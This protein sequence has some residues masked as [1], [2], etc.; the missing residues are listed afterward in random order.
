MI[1]WFLDKNS[2]IPLYLQLKD[3]IKYYISTGAIS[4]SEQLPGVINLSKELGI[5]FETVGKAYKELEKEGLIFTKRGKG[6]FVDLRK[7]PV[8]SPGN[9][10][11][12][13]I[14][15][16]PATELKHA[17]KRLLLDGKD[18]KDVESLVSGILKEV[19]EENPNAFIIFTECSDFQVQEI[20]QILKT[21]LNLDVKPVLVEDLKAEMDRI[22]ETEHNLLSIVTTGFHLNEVRKV[23]GHRP[24][25]IQILITYMGPETRSRL[26]SFSKDARFGLICRDKESL[27]VFT[28]MLKTELGKDLNLTVSILSDEPVV[29]VI[30]NSADVLLVTP[31]VYAPIKQRTSGRLPVFNIFD[32]VEPISLK[33]I[34]SNISRK[35]E[36]PIA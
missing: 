27:S 31:A 29:E 3:L 34:K 11:E 4:D 22:N 14:Q 28:D 35:L 23:V 10:F 21:Q 5:S 12:S 25:D 26:A 24:V 17:I 20:S 2:K 1:K 9:G 32:S 30:L 16:D 15:R 7:A 6:T 33:M 8:P 36:S 13:E 18:E 19:S